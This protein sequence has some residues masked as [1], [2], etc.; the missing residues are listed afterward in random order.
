[1]IEKVFRFFF[2]WYKIYWYYCHFRVLSF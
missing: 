2:I 1:L